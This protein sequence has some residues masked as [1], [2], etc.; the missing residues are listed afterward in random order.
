MSGSR[1]GGLKGI[2]LAAVTFAVTASG[3]FLL[4]EATPSAQGLRFD[5]PTSSQ[6]IALTANGATLAV[7]N[8]DNNSVTIFDVQADHFPEARQVLEIHRLTDP[9]YSSPLIRLILG[10]HPSS[11]PLGSSRRGAHHARPFFRSSNVHLSDP[12]VSACVR[13]RP[14]FLR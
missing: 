5:R 10:L 3:L 6:P 1:L 7:A 13:R 14:R 4:P 2:A 9:H 12:I 11:T 8:P